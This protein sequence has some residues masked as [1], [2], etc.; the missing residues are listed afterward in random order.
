MMSHLVVVLV[1][2]RF[3]IGTSLGSLSLSVNYFDTMLIPSERGVHSFLLGRVTN[4]TG[5][6]EAG[7]Q[8][9]R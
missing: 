7:H 6:F 9:V 5:T 1:C 8:L 3:A 4:I 2:V